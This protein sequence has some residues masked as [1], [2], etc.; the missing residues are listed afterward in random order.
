M[1]F[2]YDRQGKPLTTADITT[3]GKLLRDKKYKIVKQETTK[4]GKYF[5]ST[6][7]LGIDHSFNLIGLDQPNPNPVIFETMVFANKWLRGRDYSELDLQR[8]C[9]EAEAI[10]GH[11]QMFKK[12]NRKK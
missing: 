1:L 2:W 9:T 3:I 4:N 5:V 10:A 6:V 7:W 12:W 8:Y 11:D